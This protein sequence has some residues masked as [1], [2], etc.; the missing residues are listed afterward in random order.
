MRNKHR[1]FTE[2]R[3]ADIEQAQHEQGQVN[4]VCCDICCFNILSFLRSFLPQ[5]C[6]GARTVANVGIGTAV[7]GEG[8]ELAQVAAENTLSLVQ[9]L[10][11]YGADR[12]QDQLEDKILKEHETKT[13]TRIRHQ[14][15]EV[16]VVIDQLIV[17]VQ[18]PIIERFAER[19]VNKEEAAAI[20]KIASNPNFL[21]VT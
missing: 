18:H 5:I 21:Q 6:F 2:E 19:F 16:E 1:P 7:R 8:G 4:T 15:N 20:A 9:S 14:I 3:Q 12:A 17:N 10:V 13:E 11:N